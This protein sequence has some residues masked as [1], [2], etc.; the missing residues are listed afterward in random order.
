MLHKQI[1][2]NMIAKG[3]VLR[4]L[5]K[6]KKKKITT[7]WN[8]IPISRTCHDDSLSIDVHIAIR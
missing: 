4:D 6:L 3:I 7:K 5:T 8:I 2:N 1:I